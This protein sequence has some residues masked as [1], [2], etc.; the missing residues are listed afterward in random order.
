MYRAVAKVVAE[1]CPNSTPPSVS[2][3]RSRVAVEALRNK[4]ALEEKFVVG[5]DTVALRALSGQNGQGEELWLLGKAFRFEPLTSFPHSVTPC[6]VSGGDSSTQGYKQG[7]FVYQGLFDQNQG[8][9][10]DTKLGLGLFCSCD[11][12]TNTRTG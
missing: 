7:V 9:D 11:S 8:V 5:A 3:L 6:T 1:T 2:E 10:Q 4:T 12:G